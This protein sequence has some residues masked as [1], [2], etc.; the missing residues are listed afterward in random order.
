MSV[1]A[2]VPSGDFSPPI[3]DSEPSAPQPGNATGNAT[4]ERMAHSGGT[5]VLLAGS[6]A[7]LESARAEGRALEL[8]K[9]PAKIESNGTRYRVVV[10]RYKTS[11]DADSARR[12]YAS[13]GHAFTVLA[14]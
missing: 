14:E 12:D 11:D 13:A 2:T 1:P 10:G 4:K 7:W 5:Y 8:L 9:I 6:H 3:A